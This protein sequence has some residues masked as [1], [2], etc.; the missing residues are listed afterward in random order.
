MSEYKEVQ[1]TE[2][3]RPKLVKDCILPDYLKKTFQSFVDQK[4]VPNLLLTGPAGTGKTT[5]AK[6]MLEELD[7]EYVVINGSLYG[8]ID[9]LRNEIK[10]FASSLSLYG[11]GRKYVILDEADFLNANST[12]PA[13]RNFMEEYSALCGFI[14]T[15]NYSARIL[16]ELRSRCATV[17]FK[18]P[19][20]ERKPLMGQFLKRVMHILE[21]EGVKA[22]KAV[23]AAV[24][25]KHFPDWRK[26]LHELQVYQASTGTID[27]GALAN[28]TDTSITNLVSLMKDKNFTGCRRW[29]NEHADI[30]ASELFNILYDKAS[31]LIEPS[32]IPNLI[33]I[34]AK[35]SYQSV[36]TP[37]QEVNTASCIVEIMKECR[38]K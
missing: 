31:D 19:L 15:A 9:T 27:S 38:F 34:L 10:N 6:A 21:L 4:E 25:Q 24:I 30:E 5:V 2:I 1:W 12:Q 37:I 18:I 20:V 28:F 29:I 36:F 8:N 35:Y 22:D 16:K 3:Y 26:P 13:L 23:V 7:C 32:S 33:L 11:E 14:L 17:E